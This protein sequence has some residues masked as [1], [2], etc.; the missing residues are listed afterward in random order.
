M[1]AGKK[2][3]PLRQRV[4]EGALAGLD[5]TDDGDAAAALVELLAGGLQ[6][7]RSVL[8]QQIAQTFDQRQQTQPGLLQVRADRL[9]R[10]VQER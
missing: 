10:L 8:A 5:L 4:D 1:S 9:V 6:K 2:S 7:R 3:G